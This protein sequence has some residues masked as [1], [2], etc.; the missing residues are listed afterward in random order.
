VVNGATAKRQ[1]FVG[2]LNRGN[3]SK[4]TSPVARLLQRIF[5]RRPTKANPFFSCCA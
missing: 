5:G 3:S 2:I 4:T 1:N